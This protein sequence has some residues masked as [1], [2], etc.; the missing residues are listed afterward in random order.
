[1]IVAG[2]ALDGASRMAGGDIC[3]AFRA[4]ASGR[5][6][7][8][9]RL[10]GAPDGFFVAEARGLAML[11]TPGGPPLPEVVAVGADGLVLEW[12]E[13]ARPS[14]AAAEDFGRRLAALH[15]ARLPAFGNASQG[16]IGSLPLMNAAEPT[17]A[18]FYVKHRILPYLASLA[19]AHRHAVEQLCARIDDVAGPPEPPARIHGDL[20][21]GN[22]VWGASATWLVDAAGAHGGHRETDLA[23]LRLFGAP[24]FDAILAA[25]QEVSPLADGWRSRVP[26]HQLH[27]LLV[28]ATL[29][30]GHY[31]AQAAA[32]AAAA[33]G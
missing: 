13:P 1:M 16:F 23:M 9:K 19:G 2:V 18:A 8:A 31:G 30:G 21:S 26:L 7:F 20:W 24:H 22:L 33:L 25:Y 17:W 28:H 4:R 32:A 6:V 27:P 5:P 14:R 3:Q 29:F 15:G 11:R 12:I 10:A